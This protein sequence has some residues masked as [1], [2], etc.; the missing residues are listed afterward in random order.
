VPSFEKLICSTPLPLSVAERVNCAVVLFVF[1]APPLIATEPVGAIVSGV[2]VCVAVGVC[3]SVGVGVIV[4]VGVGVG[5]GGTG[6]G[7]G[8]AWGR[9]WALPGSACV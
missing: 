5:V 8:V 7:V 9:D 2:G 4:G 1:A 6:V 3:V